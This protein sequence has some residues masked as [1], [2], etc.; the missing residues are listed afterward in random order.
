MCSLV[1]GQRILW[2]RANRAR[3]VLR[4]ELTAAG[5]HLEEAIVYRHHDVEA[6]SEEVNQRLIAGQLDWIGVSSPAIA[7]NVAR[8]LPELARSQLGSRIRIAS[9][10]PVTSAACQEVG[11]PVSA[12]ATVH[13]WEGILAVICLI[14]RNAAQG[15]GEK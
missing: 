7:R 15:A 3:E 11:L 8:L 1:S 6:W 2:A 10:S 9:I 4:T 5:A 13:T 12:E 14:E